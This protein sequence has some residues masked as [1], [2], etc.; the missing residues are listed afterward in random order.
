MGLI[1]LV[2]GFYVVEGWRGRRAWAE[3]EALA[4]SRGESLTLADFVLPPIPDADNFA[5]API[6][7]ELFSSDE[8]IARAALARLRLRGPEGV[9]PQGN[10][11][12]LNVN[13]LDAWRRLLGT[14]DLLAYLASYETDLEQISVG[15]RRP[16]ARFSS[17][18]MEASD[19]GSPEGLIEAVRLLRLRAEARM[20]RG[21]ASGAA[22]D[23]LA[24]FGVAKAIGAEPTLLYQLVASAITDHGVR[25][26][27]RGYATDM[28]SKTELMALDESLARLDFLDGG[29][30]S[31]RMELAGN[32]T[33]IRQAIE[34][35]GGAAAKLVY[36]DRRTFSE[37]LAVMVRPSGWGFRQTA[38]DALAWMDNLLPAYDPATRRVDYRLLAAWD[39]Y[40]KQRSL[41]RVAPIVTQMHLFLDV[42]VSRQTQIDLARTAMALALW[43]REHG[44]YPESLAE[45]PSGA[46]GVGG[47]H[48]LVT[49]EP[50]HYRKTGATTFL[51]YATGP[52]GIDDGGGSRTDAN[53]RSKLGG[54]DWVW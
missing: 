43:Q 52:D 25:A 10:E 1:T 12:Y 38:S 41:P 54:D 2:T 18:V 9:I 14:Q 5:K 51:L 34:E 28:W 44:A 49:G 35:P 13:T 27:R 11:D 33:V 4:R 3:V 50:F 37:K 23:L 47:L 16:S 19:V 7:A 29:W 15:A 24:I 53:G 26:L 6:I 42:F 32:S 21:Q 31:L 17:W 22:N 20:E 45:L 48:D 40:S 39:A 36:G 46:Q 8:K 30:R